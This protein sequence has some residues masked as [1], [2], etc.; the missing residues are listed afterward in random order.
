MLSNRASG[1]RDHHG[2]ILG[3]A[4]WPAIIRRARLQDPEPPHQQM[5]AV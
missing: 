4:V 1:Q 2:E 5:R 3:K